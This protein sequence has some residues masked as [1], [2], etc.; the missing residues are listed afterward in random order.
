MLRALLAVPFLLVW[1]IPVVY[2]Y[3]EREGKT[4]FDLALHYA[5]YVSMGWLSFLI[6]FVMMRDVLLVSLAPGGASYGWVETYGGLVVFCLSV[7]SVLLGVATAVQG[8]AVRTINVPIDNLAPELEGCRIVQISDL[9]VGPTIH[10]PYVERVVALAT[11]LKPDI[12][13][14]T[15]DLI[16]GT[17]AEL[18]PH[19]APLAGLAP[20]KPRF[21]ITGNHEYYSGGAAWCAH[22][23]ALGY[24]VLT[25]EH[26]VVM[27]GG[28]PIVVA[29]VVDPAVKMEDRQ[30]APDPA[31]ALQRGPGA[32]GAFKILLAH[33]PRLAKLGAAAGYD[34][35]LSGHTHAGQFFPWTFVT[36]LIHKPHYAGLSKRGSMWVYVS[37]GT[38]SWGPP[39]RLGTRQELT[40]IC[41]TRARA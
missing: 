17:V 10:K 31:G 41:L 19:V 18:A 28:K 11:A 15:G 21:F 5:A 8:P 3:G 9:H 25:N 29:G 6:I 40:L 14:L 7:F 27:H 38:G 22:V 33:N 26:A 4:K 37:A 1:A 30:M 36:W 23:A 2:W 32:V 13:A 34:L 39:I 20:D 24:Q 35:Q 16:D 12:V